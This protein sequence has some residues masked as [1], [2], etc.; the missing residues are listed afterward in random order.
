MEMHQI[1]Y[2]LTLWKERHFTRAARRSGVSQPS[3]SNA[4][5]A[6]ER[7]LGGALFHRLPHVAPTALG[8]AVAPCLIRIAESVEQTRAVAQAL[9][10]N[11]RPT[12]RES[13]RAPRSLPRPP[14]GERRSGK[15][16]EVSRGTQPMPSYASAAPPR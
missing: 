2:F 8:M 10:D 3:L 4:I 12:S 7:E 16:G 6:L 14:A 9:A 15:R 11:G 13:R 5:K 1:R